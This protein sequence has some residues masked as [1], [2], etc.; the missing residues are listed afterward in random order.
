MRAIPGMR[1]RVLLALVIWVA[2][3]L[4]ARLVDAV[5]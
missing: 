1:V 3:I 4:V 5:V 2:L